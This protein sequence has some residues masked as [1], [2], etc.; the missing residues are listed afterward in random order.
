MVDVATLDDWYSKL[1]TQWEWVAGCGE[2][3]V[4]WNSEEFQRWHT[5]QPVRARESLF[6]IIKS[7]VGNNAAAG[8]ARIFD[9]ESGK[10]RICIP[11][12]MICLEDEET[13]KAYCRAPDGLT[14]LNHARAIWKSV[15]NAHSN[16][17][18]QKRQASPTLLIKA[19]R[20]YRNSRQAHLLE[21]E[22]EGVFYADLWHLAHEAGIII[23][24]LGRAS[25]TCTVSASSV[26]KVWAGRHLEL[27][28]LLKS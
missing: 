18:V 10:D 7:V 6:L 20:E 17:S 4:L 13:A 23:E 28:E 8:V 19:F 21:N 27:F 16:L 9:H 11:R 3:A 24:S 25:D 1:R 22:P 5:E 15:Q 2:F 12:L 14:H 26:G